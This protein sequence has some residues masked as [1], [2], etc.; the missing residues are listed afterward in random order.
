MRRLYL[1]MSVFQAFSS[2]LKHSCTSRSSSAVPASRIGGKVSSLVFS[3]IKFS[4]VAFRLLLS[5]GGVPKKFFCVP[6]SILFNDGW[7]EITEVLLR[8][9]QN[10]RTGQVHHGELLGQHLLHSVID[11][12]ALLKIESN[13]LLLH[14]LV[15]FRFPW[16]GW[17]F[18]THVPQV[19]LPAG[20]QDV[21]VRRWIGIAADQTH[22][23][24]IIVMRIEHAICGRT[25]FHRHHVC[26]NPYCL[27]VILHQG[28]YLSALRVAG[29]HQNRELHRLSG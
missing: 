11:F 17:S 27:Q 22:Y 21:H 3:S 16:R 7:M 20:N 14:E 18:L 25:D 9:D 26:R 1:S 5:G 29:T 15:Q 2:P 23:D 28:C 24:G 19:S 6:K 4:G 10:I 8:S 13:Q 12:F